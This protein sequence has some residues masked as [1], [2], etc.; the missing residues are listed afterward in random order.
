MKIF[1]CI[2]FSNPKPHA[3][4]LFRTMMLTFKQT[5]CNILHIKFHASESSGSEKEIFLIFSYIFL[6]FK[7]GSPCE[8]V[9]WTYI[10]QK[11]S[12]FPEGRISSR[13][14]DVNKGRAARFL[15]YS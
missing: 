13:R 11:K 7:P 1:K 9:F 15:A 8:G 5:L 12:R 14:N 4:E 6:W 10:A 3:T 2:L